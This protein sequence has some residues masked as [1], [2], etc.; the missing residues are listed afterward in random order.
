MKP[1]IAC[2]SD[3]RNWAFDIGQKKM[4]KYLSDSFN[5]EQY[6]VVEEERPDPA[7][8]DMMF[9]PYHEWDIS[10][11]PKMPLFGSLRSQHFVPSNPGEIPTEKIEYM[12]TCVGFHVINQRSYDELK[13]YCPHLTYL[14]NPVDMGKYTRLSE[15][16]E[17][18]CC[19]N[20]NAD[21]I[22]KDS[23]VK[24]YY[25]ILKPACEQTGVLF[26]VAEYHTSRL[27]PEEMPDFYLRS[28]IALCG[29]L[30]EGASNSVLESMASGLAV[31][32][33]DVGNAR[34]MQQSQLRHLGNT[35]IMI[36][37]RNVD[38]FVDAINFLKAAPGKIK[39]MGILNRQEIIDRWSWE[40][41][42]D[43]YRD[44]LSSALERVH[45]QN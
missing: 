5:F 37:D 6:Y 22:E 13:P 44:A 27:P 20:G 24:G 43:R 33:T 34:E 18:I 41:W 25:G 26:N 1:L 40:A 30:Y 12:N 21:R 36:I 42:A 3:V 29:S 35:G 7:R 39:E 2:I 10:K 14:T 45:G 9:S 28:S 38:S 19:W 32:T 15:I 4:I 11:D 31:I 16:K 23:D 17:P 8:T